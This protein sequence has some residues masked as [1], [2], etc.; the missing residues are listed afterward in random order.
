MQIKPNFRKRC[1][2]CNGTG[3]ISRDCPYDPICA[4]RK[5]GGHKKHD[6][7][8]Y[9]VEQ[10]RRDYGKYAPKIIEGFQE[11]DVQEETD[12]TTTREVRTENESES[13]ERCLV[14]LTA[15]VLMF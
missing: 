11:Q 3:H 12:K 10:A 7:D 13:T 5:K 1:L 15:S 14:L 9:K 6:S 2:I 4:Y 8:L